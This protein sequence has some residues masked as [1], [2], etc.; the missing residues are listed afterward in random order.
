MTMGEVSC[1]YFQRGFTDS[2]TEDDSIATIG[3][4]THPRIKRDNPD[5]AACVIPR[6][7][8]RQLCPGLSQKLDQVRQEFRYRCTIHRVK[9]LDP[10][11]QCKTLRACPLDREELVS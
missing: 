4:C 3:V 11:T 9:V 5:C 10:F 2:V 1:R 7:A 8:H 6:L